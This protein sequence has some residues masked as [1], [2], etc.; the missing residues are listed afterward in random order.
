MMVECELYGRKIIGIAK[1]RHVQAEKYCGYLL[2][3]R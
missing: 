3:S 1:L 2:N